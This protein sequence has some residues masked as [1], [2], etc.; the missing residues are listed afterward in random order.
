MYSEEKKLVVVVL[1]LYFLK[2]CNT[3]KIWFFFCASLINVEKEEFKTYMYYIFYDDII[4]INEEHCWKLQNFA[5]RRK[6]K[7]NQFS[8]SNIRKKM[9]WNAAGVKL[10]SVANLM[11]SN[12][13]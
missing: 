3:I 1:I 4:E 11:Q 5:K 6:R 12:Y 13:E 8:Q 10:Y 9:S 2:H 7:K